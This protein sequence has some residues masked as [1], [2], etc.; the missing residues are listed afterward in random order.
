M[1]MHDMSTTLAA[2]LQS[3][4]CN[5]KYV[6][7]NVVVLIYITYANKGNVRHAAVAANSH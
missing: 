3:L 1:L 7:V 2:A 4:V 6:T 5:S